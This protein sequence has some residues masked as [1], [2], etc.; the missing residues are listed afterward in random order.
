MTLENALE[1]AGYSRG[2]RSSWNGE[3]FEGARLLRI[4]YGDGFVLP[5]LDIAE[6]VSDNGEFLIIDNT[7]PEYSGEAA[8]GH[9]EPTATC[10]RCDGFCHEEDSRV[11][12]PCGEYEQ[13]WCESCSDYYASYCDYCD[14][15]RESDD[16]VSLY[17]DHYQNDMVCM[18]SDCA[19]DNRVICDECNAEFDGDS[20]TLIYCDDDHREYCQE[21][22][23]N[24]PD[25][26]TF[27]EDD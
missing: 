1:N 26:M 15:Q 23:D 4:P 9:T 13:T 17:T 24:H 6:G 5:Y 12:A 21:C 18:C 3:T 10:E 22:Y 16:I 25:Q 27:G 19:E 8:S 11:V 2:S 20:V 7:S 14:T